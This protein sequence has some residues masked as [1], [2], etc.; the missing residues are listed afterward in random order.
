MKLHPS[1]SKDIIELP[2]AYPL[3]ISQSIGVTPTF[4]RLHFHTALEINY[5][6]KGSGYYLING[7]RHEFQQGDLVFIDSND[8]HR[9]FE[10]KEL[11]M[12][13]IMFDPVY[14]AL[15]QRYAPELLV[16]FRE[17]G[18]RFENRLDRSNPMHGR[19]G[20]IVSDMAA[21]YTRKEPYFEV[22]VRAQLIQLLAFVNRYFAK[23]DAAKAY[24]KRGWTL[25]EPYC[26]RS[27]M[28]LCIHGL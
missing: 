8:L 14:L 13:V 21:E 1:I 19:I 3:V 17:L 11:V 15:E 27:R 12:S 7:N 28:T 4:Q 24:H 2:H 5:I 6:E 9:A 23:N 16:P 18:N 25:F 22:I 10:E 20:G 26:A